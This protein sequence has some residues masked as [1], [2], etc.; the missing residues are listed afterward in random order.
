M[1]KTDTVS[2]KGGSKNLLCSGTVPWLFSQKEK[3]K[4]GW[5]QHKLHEKPTSEVTWNENA[6]VHAAQAEKYG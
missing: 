5:L 3:T 4:S 2:L 6:P 1:K